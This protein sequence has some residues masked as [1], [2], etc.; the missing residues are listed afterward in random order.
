MRP[1]AGLVREDSHGLPDRHRRRQRLRHQGL[2]PPQHRHPLHAAE[3]HRADRPVHAGAARLRRARRREAA[4]GV[5]PPVARETP[6]AQ[7]LRHGLRLRAPSSSRRAAI[8]ASGSSRPGKQV[9]AKNP[10]K[11]VVTPEGELSEARTER[12][13][14]PEGPR[15]AAGRRPAPR[16]GPL[17]LRRRHQP[18]GRRDGQALALARHAR[19]EPA[20]HLP[21]SRDQV[22]RLAARRHERQPDQETSASTRIRRAATLASRTRASGAL[23][24]S[25]KPA[26]GA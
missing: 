17:P 15:R 4:G 18:D 12:V 26:P 8:S 16:R 21:R 7:G 1:W 13:H 22:R 2:R 23:R 25:E 14:H 9:E 6:G 3:P 11:V 20:V 19:E 10:G 5:E 24:D